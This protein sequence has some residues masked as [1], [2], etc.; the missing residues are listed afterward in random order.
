METQ[1]EPIAEVTFHVDYP[2][3]KAYYIWSILRY[4][5]SAAVLISFIILPLVI[6][7]LLLWRFFASPLGDAGTGYL[8]AAVG[9]LVCSFT[10]FVL[11]LRKPSRIYQK[12]RAEF[13]QQATCRFYEDCFYCIGH[14]GFRNESWAGYEAFPFITETASAFY[15]QNQEKRYLILP[16]RFLSH[17]QTDALRALFQRQLMGRFTPYCQK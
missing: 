6:T 9:L 16:K 7:A 14:T 15:L 3:Y 17:E 12:R 5:W 11:Q 1:Q 2:S 10:M 13:E 8:F 4:P